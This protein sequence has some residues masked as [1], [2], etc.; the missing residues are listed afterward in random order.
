M[1]MGWWTRGKR[2][3]DQMIERVGR[4]WDEGVGGETGWGRLASGWRRCH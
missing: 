2:E 1:K 3:L 4:E